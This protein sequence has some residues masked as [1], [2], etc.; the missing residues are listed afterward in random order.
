MSSAPSFAQLTDVQVGIGSPLH[1]PID[2][3]DPNGN[4]LTVTVTS[5]NPSLLTAQVLA[6]NRS[7]RI[8][9]NNFGDMVF[10]LFEDRAPVPSGR[11]IELAQD[12]F[13][14]GVIFHRVINNFVIQG[15]DPTGTG[16]GG[17]T[18]GDFDDQFHLDLQHNRTGVLS[19]AKSSDDT[20]DS[21]FFITEGPQ[22]NLDFNHSVFGQ[23]VEGEPVRQSISDTATNASDRPLNNVV[24]E[25]ATVFNDLENAVVMLKASGSG[26]GSATITVTVSDTE[27]NS[28]SQSFVASVIADTANGAP[29]LNPIADVTTSVNTPVD[30]NLTSQDA[31]GDTVIYSVQPA[32]NTSFNV[33]V[34]SAT[35]VARVTPPTGFVGQLQFMATVRQNGTTT[36]SST[37]DNQL[38]TVN[39]VQNAPT[40]IDLLA[41]SDSGSSSTDN[42]TNANSLSF[43]VAGTTL[44]ATVEVRAGGT[45]VGTAIAA[46]NSTV[47][48][49]NNVAALGQGSRLFTATQIVGGQVSGA[50]PALA[51]VLDSSAPAVIGSG[52]FPTSAVVNQNVSLDLAHPEEGQGLVYALATAPAGMTIGSQNG[53]VAWTPTAAQLGA[54]ALTLSLTDAAGN[55]STQ[56]ISINVIEEPL[57]Q[58]TL[59]AVSL[60]GQP[61]TTVAVGEQFKVQVSVQDL[62]AGSA[63]TGVFATY[64]DLLFDSSVIQPIATSPITHVDPYD[65]DKSGTVGV[66]LIDEL[67]AFSSRTNP[68]GPDGRLFAEVTFIALASGDAG[69]RTES[70]DEAGNDVLLY[71]Q[72]T[73]IAVARVAYGDS[74]FAVGANFDVL[75]DSYNF[76]E[77][78]GPH[79]LDVLANDP[80]NNSAVL[81]ITGVGTASNGGAVTIASDGKT[82][83]YKSAANFNGAEIFTYT[84]SNT[85]GVT[86]TATVTVQ[87]TD[88][89]D[90]P[91]ALNDT[92]SVLQNSTNN[93]LEVLSNDSLGVD[94][95]AGESLRVTAVS[96]GS[97]GGTIVIGSS[98]LTVRYTPAVG[99]QGSETFTYTLGDGRGGTATATVSVSVD[100]EN[101]PPTPQNDSFTVVE[102]AP[103]ASFDVLANDTT[104]DPTETLSVASVSASQFESQVTVSADGLSIIYRPAANFS[105][106]EILS[107]TVRDSNGATATGLVTFNVTPVNDPPN[108]VDDIANLL[109]SQ[110]SSAINVLVNDINP[111]QNETL[112]ITAVSQPPTGSGT[113][114][115][116]ADGKS[117]NYVPPSSSFA[118]SFAFTYTIGDGT[119]LSD[120]AT[121]NVTV[122]DY[123]ARSIG[124]TLTAMAGV[125]SA[126]TIGGVTVKL[127]G[128]DITGQSVEELRQVSA[129]GSYEFSDLA[130]G[131]YRLVRDPV[132]FLIDS[133]ET[134]TVNS[135]LEDGD[136]VIDLTIS[137]AMHPRYFDIRDFLGSTLQNSLTIAV[138]G[139]G[140]QNWLAPRGSWTQLS[141]LN[142]T[143][144]LDSLQIAAVNVSQQSLSRTLPIDGTRVS[145]V[146]SESAMRLLRVRGSVGDVALRPVAPAAA[147][148][149]T[150]G[151][152]LV[153]EGEGEGF[154]APAVSS[155]I[156]ALARPLSSQASKPGLPSKPVSSP[157]QQPLQTSPVEASA[158]DAAMQDMLPQLR[159]QLSSDLETLL[160]EPDPADALELDKLFGGI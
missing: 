85:Q 55:V 10:E 133:G 160:S 126:N 11:V 86:R 38:V 139:D 21:Q 2:A 93:L 61:L 113:I 142:A 127:L 156:E 40:A 147:S 153:G 102:D 34:N 116:A 88:V 22:R 58:I 63:R 123:I 69:L 107:Y 150:S 14:D 125:S 51:V 96:S 122:R 118:G 82:L 137:G 26:T 143:A 103:Q 84:A 12:G 71:D 100:Q 105:G 112:T 158:V 124:G 68:L 115:I 138:N 39:V 4:P 159:R 6:N 59:N 148:S 50:S 141:A 74:Q 37:T 99:F 27:G 5:S 33:T 97:A 135:N 41:E 36:T 149:D 72:S 73:P 155:A 46:G 7:L 134:I 145:H 78:T 119:G 90:P 151:A 56:Q 140:T 47:V 128:T 23:L 80:V 48:T 154:A 89:N 43:A 67:G 111:D 13:Y 9:N 129:N 94:D 132:P 76:D 62:R 114:S 24:I 66:G 120:T 20:N 152:G 28:S 54:Q 130:P 157:L 49:V 117:L 1:I 110:S 18:L 35:G 29:F 106:Q 77:D 79:V 70:A 109:S 52:V 75:D 44:G 146:G 19:Y 8:S 131:D 136:A 65:N 92:F 91:I 60:T 53:Q 16:S 15:G 45:V 81:S 98:G 31:E 83:S 17:S 121:V 32:G 87:I 42:V 104:N 25:S 3:Y 144:E 57:M 30:V 64:L 95:E 101:P 108:A